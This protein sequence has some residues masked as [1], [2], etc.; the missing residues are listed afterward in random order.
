MGRV[1]TPF[2]AG[3][4]DQALRVVR[5]YQAPPDR[6]RSGA[7]QTAIV[8]AV[9]AWVKALGTAVDTAE[10]R[11]A[12]LRAGAEVAPAAPEIA[13]QLAAARTGA[14]ASGSDDSHTFGGLLGGLPQG[15]VVHPDQIGSQC[16]QLR[17]TPGNSCL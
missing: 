16:Q 4:L 14:P 5:R 3:A 2:T 7:T 6:V 17:D 13:S 9:E 1:P 15:I 11:L 10:A 8:S 12:L